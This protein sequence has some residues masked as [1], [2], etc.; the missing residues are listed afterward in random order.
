[1]IKKNSDT[2]QLI[3][4]NIIKLAI[5][6]EETNYS[7]TRILAIFLHENLKSLSDE[8]IIEISRKS[9]YKYFMKYLKS[10][11]N[12]PL[13]NHSL[14]IDKF[15]EIFMKDDSYGSVF[16]SLVD[17]YR[18]KESE[19]DKYVLN[20]LREDF[21]ASSC[22][23]PSEFAARNQMLGKISVH[24]RVGDVIYYS[25]FEKAP[26]FMINKIHS[27]L[28]IMDVKIRLFLT[29]S[30]FDTIISKA[31]FNE[32]LSQKLSSNVKTIKPKVIKI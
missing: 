7:Y 16:R 2:Y 32:S 11:K 31:S 29:N 9:G 5:I 23:T 25:Y 24:K 22:S 8:K 28:N 18:Q 15:R 1:M 19:L 27:T 26:A 3:K 6:Q 4:D 10:Y 14:L 12:K 21:P 13:A 17:F 20:Q 30:D